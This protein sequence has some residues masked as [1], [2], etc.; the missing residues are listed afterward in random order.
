MAVI[1]HQIEENEVLVFNGPG[2]QF[3]M[4]KFNNWVM[5]MLAKCNTV[6]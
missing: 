5:V 6:I 2:C 1:R 4:S 3:G